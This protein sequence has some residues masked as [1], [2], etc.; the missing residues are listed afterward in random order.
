MKVVINI[1]KPSDKSWKVKGTTI[2]ELFKNLNKHKWWGR[3]RSNE[4]YKKKKGKDG[5]FEQA[6]IIGAP[7]VTMPSW[8]NY[9]KASK[10]EKKSWDDMW[11]A[12]KVHELNHHKIFEKE[13]EAWKKWMADFE[14]VDQKTLTAEWDSFKKDL[15]KAQDAYDKKSKHGKSEGVI[16]MEV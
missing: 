15:Q 10:E 13:A 16:L 6:T 8:V 3:Y 5:Y 12:L 4:D 2:A 1:K 14:E 9:S 11:K 7:V